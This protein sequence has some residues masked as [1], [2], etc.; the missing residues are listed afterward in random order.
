MD[1]VLCVYLYKQIFTYIYL[2]AELRYKSRQSAAAQDRGG[3]QAAH[4]SA[5]VSAAPQGGGDAFQDLS[6]VSHGA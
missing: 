1:R 4:A 6:H 3:E 5:R 2:C